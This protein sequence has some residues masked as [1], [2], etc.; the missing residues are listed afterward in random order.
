VTAMLKEE[1]FHMF[2]GHTGLTRILRAG[3][4][5]VA[6]VQKVLQQMVVDGV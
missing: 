1:F 3:K 5:P 6:I 2:T 4:I